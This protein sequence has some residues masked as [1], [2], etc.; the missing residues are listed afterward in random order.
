MQ[1]K[2]KTKQKMCV[3]AIWICI[4]KKK[5]KKY[6]VKKLVKFTDTASPGLISIM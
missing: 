4:I 5:K 3:R 1:L 6:H 2:N